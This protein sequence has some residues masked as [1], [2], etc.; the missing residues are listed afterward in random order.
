MYRTFFGSFTYEERRRTLFRTVL[1]QQQEN[2]IQAKYKIRFSH[3]LTLTFYKTLY[4]EAGKKLPGNDGSNWVRQSHIQ[5]TSE[6]IC[7][8]RS[9]FTTE[10][11]Q[12]RR[13]IKNKKTEE[14]GRKS[15]MWRDSRRTACQPTQ[16]LLTRLVSHVHNIQT[17]CW[18]NS[19][20]RGR[21][22]SGARLITFT[23]HTHTQAHTDLVAMASG[24]DLFIYP[25]WPLCLKMVSK[26]THIFISIHPAWCHDPLS[27]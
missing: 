20:V 22:G 4:E 3:G 12:N 24:P 26:H 6:S 1:S 8:G 21:A 15:K 2:L 13:W 11:C 10:Q 23:Y 19:S 16:R 5:C 9:I 25:L 17:G 7:G 27:A 14:S 18:H